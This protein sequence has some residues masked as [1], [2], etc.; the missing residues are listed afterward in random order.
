MVT[1]TGR[2]DRDRPT[3]LLRMADAGDL[4]LSWR[5]T[6]DLD[7]PGASRVPEEQLRVALD[8]LTAALPGGT[9]ST[10]DGSGARALGDAGPPGLAAALTSG[11]FAAYEAELALAELLSRTFLPYGLAVVLHEL[12]VRGI[13]PHVRIQPSPR[14]AQVPWELL[15]PDRDIRFVDIADVSVLAPAS[16]VHAPARPVRTWAGSRDLPVAAILDPRVPGFR[17]DS[18]L[19]SV[20]GRMSA[21]APLTRR[22]AEHARRG[23]LRPVLPDSPQPGSARGVEAFRRTDLDREWLGETLRAGASR[24]L[25]V[26]HVTASVPETGLSEDARLHLACTAD[27]LGFAPPIRGHRPLS[28]KDLLLGTHTLTEVPQSGAERWPIP[29]R[30]A[31]IAC[32]SGGDLRFGEALGLATAMI[33]GGAELVTATRWTLPTDL[34]FQRLAG[35]DPAVRPL[36]DAILAI[37]SAHE[38]DDPVRAVARWQRERLA[39]WRELRGVEHSPLLWGAFTTIDTAGSVP[40]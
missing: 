10:S 15:A 12:M 27:T 28:A 39:A 32:E 24:L 16:I 33:H 30:V 7:R 14:L 26:G 23:R 9:S 38:S 2:P 17:A 18:V 22:I 1:M 40:G 37:D 4:Y 3:V 6:H 36:Q 20:L 5:W 11:A 34:A 29:S 31:L 8:A 25:Y 13:R 35:V 21:D 19:G